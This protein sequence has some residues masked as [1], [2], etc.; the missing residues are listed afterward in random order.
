MAA[1]SGPQRPREAFLGAA[2]Q[3][4]ATS[5]TTLDEYNGSFSS[6]LNLQE[7]LRSG[8][9]SSYAEAIG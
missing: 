8:R 9:Q 1:V 4:E 7:L 2:G 3:G 6:L 5:G